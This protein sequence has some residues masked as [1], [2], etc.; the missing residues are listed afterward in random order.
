[1]A[2]CDSRSPVVGDLVAFA[3]KLSMAARSAMMVVAVAARQAASNDA[4]IKSAMSTPKEV[5]AAE[6]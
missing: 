4:L 5:V 6:T 2:I 3:A 1:M